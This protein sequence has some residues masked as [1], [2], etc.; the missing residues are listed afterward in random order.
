MSGARRKFETHGVLLRALCLV[1]NCCST[2]SNSLVSYSLSTPTRAA[3]FSAA[4]HIPYSDTYVRRATPVDWFRACWTTGKHISHPLFSVPPMHALCRCRAAPFSTELHMHTGGLL[5]RWRAR[6]FRRLRAVL[7]GHFNLVPHLDCRCSLRALSAGIRAAPSG[8]ELHES[9]DDLL[10]RGRARGFGFARA[11][12]RGHFRLSTPCWWYVRL[13]P[14]GHVVRV[15]APGGACGT[16][17][18]LS[19][20]VCVCLCA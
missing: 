2:F 6:R 3:S 12:C 14:H 16:Y 7:H 11:V 20:R 9:T 4:Q 8:T 5:V 13:P 17:G 19:V 1:Q 15:H 18:C 10:A